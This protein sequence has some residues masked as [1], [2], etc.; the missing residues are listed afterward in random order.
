LDALR[1]KGVY[2]AQ[3]QCRKVR[4]GKKDWS[5]KTTILGIRVL[6]WKLACNRAYRAKVQ[7][8]YHARPRKKALLQNVKFPDTIA[9][10]V[11]KPKE[12]MSNWSKY[13]KSEAE[14][15]R[16]TSLQK[17]STATAIAEDKNTTMEKIV[18]QP[19]LIEDQKRSATQIKIVRV[20]LRSGGVSRV[21]YLDENGVV[22]ESTG[23][24]HLEELCNKA[25]EAKLQQTAD[26]PFMTGALQEDVGWLGIGPAVCMMLDDTYEPTDEVDAY[27]K[28]LIKQFQKNRKATEH[29]PLYKITPEE[30]NYFWK[31]ATK[32][33]SCGCDILHFGT[34]K[35]GSFSETIMELDALL[36]DSPLQTG[37]SPLRWRVAID[38]LLLKKA[39]VMLI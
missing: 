1:K 23:R 30:W 35:G 12:A 20:K 9:G 4:T 19:R 8:R 31:G 15:D 2:E 32:R 28:K 18:K 22:H 36:T 39:G 5:P 37:Y 33:T 7:R 21:T 16:K 25:N 24:E 14:E 34:W 27:T 10:I 11:T 38:D 17:K 6:F 13:S 29:D 26:T 3:Q